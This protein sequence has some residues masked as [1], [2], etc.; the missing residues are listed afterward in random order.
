MPLPVLRVQD[1]KTYF[2]TGAG[3]TRAVDQISYDIGRGEIVGL[4]GES[5]CGKTVS[6]LSILQLIQSPPG[7]IVGGRI[8]LEGRN[9]LDLGTREMESVRGDQISMIFQEPM[10][11]LN[12]IFS[13]GEQVSE[14]LRI[15]RGLS[16][17]AALDQTV[18]MLELVG[19]PSPERRVSEYPHQ[20]SGGMRQRVMIAMAL[21]CQ[22]KVLIADEPTTA[23]DVTIQAQ[24]LELML[25]L[26][27]ELNMAIL[28]ITHDLGVVAET[29]ERVVVMYAGK[30]VE[31]ATARTIFRS[32]LHPYTI[33]LL[34]SVPSLDNVT[35]ERRGR[36]R[37]QE[38]PGLVPSLDNL[39]AGCNFQPRCARAMDV[40]LGQE[41]DLKEIEA[42]HLVRCW[43]HA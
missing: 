17:R 25:S 11:S 26:R 5:G 13:I 14:S 6:A 4:V 22:P 32:P 40:C 3:V 19:I 28:L 15:H 29:T 23:L 37:L 31:E 34:G 10:S 12:P 7:R 18:K 30:V 35:R 2:Y 36:E 43:L 1:L 16:K 24:I 20:M 8:E 27:Q 21:S 33:G 41:P 42:G 38:I 9:L 39:P